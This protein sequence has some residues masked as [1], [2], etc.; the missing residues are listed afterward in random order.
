M[1]PFL[2]VRHPPPPTQIVRPP[3]FFFGRYAS[4]C[5]THNTHTTPQKDSNNSNRLWFPIRFPPPFPPS[6]SSS[7]F[8]YH[9]FFGIFPH[10]FHALPLP[11]TPPKPEQFGP[12]TPPPL[13]WLFLF[14]WLIFFL[15][16]VFPPSP[17]FA[18]S[19]LF[20]VVPTRQVLIP[21]VWLLLSLFGLQ[22]SYPLL[23]PGC[24]P[25]LCWLLYCVSSFTV[26]LC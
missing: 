5:T 11:P 26:A 25:F 20:G 22:F 10:F 17:F 6:R 15:L 18:G 19:S 12:C 23:A 2:F 7:A 4:F 8:D 1:S 21:W 9:F 13:P 14:G 24:C 3:H 16:P